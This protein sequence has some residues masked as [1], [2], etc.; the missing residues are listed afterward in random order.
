MLQMRCQLV[1]V[2]LV[3]SLALSSSRLIGQARTEGQLSGKVA[4]PSG[5]AVAGVNLTLNQAATGINVT[6]TSTGS[7]EYVFATVLPGTY[8]LT[9]AAKGFS[10]AVYDDVHVYTGRTTNLDLTLRVGSESQTVNVSGVSEVL[11]TTT[12][13]LTTT[14]AA[15]SIQNLPLNGRDVLPFAQLVPGA[16]VGGDLRFTTYN[17][18]PN[19]AISISLDGTNNNFQRFRTSTTGFF[20]AAALRVGAIDEVSISTSDLTADAAAEGAVTLR[21]TT[22]RGTNQFHGSAFWQAYNSAFNANS[23]QN[24]AYLG[25]GLTSLGRKQPFHTNDFGANIG[26]PII[27]NKLFFFFNFEWENQPSTVL[28]TQGV[29]TPAAQAGTFTYTRADNGQQQTVNLYNVAAASG[30]PAT[31]NANVQSALAAVNTLATKGTLSPNT[32][33]SYLQSLQNTLNFTAPQN[34]KQRWPTGRL[35]YVITPNIS[36]RASYDLYWRQYPRTPIYPDGPVEEGGFQSSYSTFSTGVNWTISSNL[37]NQTNFGILNTQERAQPGNSFNAFQGIDFVPVASPFAVNS[38]PAFTPTVPDNNSILPEPRNN[39]VWDFTDNMTWSHGKHTLTFGGHYRFSNQHDVNTQP[40]I[41]QNLG[42]SANDP[43]AA[44]FNTSAVTGCTQDTQGCFPGGLSTDNNNEALTDAEALYS[45]L[46]GRVASI[47]GL[48]P[49]DTTSKTYRE[50][51][52]TSIKEK[53]AVGGFYFQDGW[54]VTPNLSMNFG[55][56]WQFSSS[57]TNTDNYFTSPTLAD[58]Y[59]PSGGLFQPGVLSGNPN[60][61]LQLRA[62]SYPGD[63]RQPAPNFGFAWNPEAHDGW[64]KTFAGGHS[65]VI[66]GGVAVNHYDEGWIPWENVATGTLSNQTVS[67]N[68]GQFTPGSISFDATGGSIPPL[69][70]IPGSFSLPMPESAL[71]FTRDGAFST[72]DPKIRTPYIENW[73]FGF[74]KR[75]GGNWA[76]DV[77]YVGN[78]AVHMWEAFD[79]N[80]VNIFQNAPGLNSFLQDFQNA[81][82][83]LTESGGT[84][85]AG[86]HATPILSQA[87]AGQPIGSTFQNPN[88]LYLVQTGQA[89]ALAG[90][91]TRNPTFFCNLVGNTFSPCVTQ[92]YKTGAPGPLTYPINFFQVNPYSGGQALT[93]L[94]DPGSESYNGLQVQVKHPVGHG[95][96][97]MANYTYSHSFTNRYLGDYYQADG[98]LVDFTTLRNP[99]LNRVPSPYDLRNVFKTYFNY[100]LPFGKGT[101]FYSQH[102][103]VNQVIGGWTLGSVVAAQT[104]RNFKLAGGVNTYNYF[105]GPTPAN[106]NGTPAGI[107][108]YVPDENDSGV[109]LNGITPSQLQK[110]VG[111]Y[112]TGNPSAPVSVL[113]ASLFG[114]GGAIQ[115]SSTPGQLGSVIFLKGPKLFNTDLSVI[116]NIP[117]RENIK[118][119]LYAEML[120]VFNHPNFNFTDSYS[121]GTNNPAQYLLVNSSPYAP[122]T[123]GQNGN[124][125]IQF[126]IQVAF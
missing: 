33:D 97:F 91:I 47:S 8:K 69:N 34:T 64:M 44:M 32:T 53:Q 117:I 15:D 96:N 40:P 19:G 55:F 65:L 24:D 28:F 108:N 27:R 87:Y 80:E 20:E 102:A 13:T 49:L 85:F 6:A 58:L 120:N 26:G 63:F 1:A 12:N 30:Y 111:V 106:A 95:L 112:M 79:L 3:A 60:P 119:N 43:A 29:L 61:Q 7:G 73:T 25:A 35:D 86:S 51:G 16:Q 99:K 37:I 14:V 115:P 100:A 114:T 66:R 5:A 116:K 104:G 82:L 70:S 46:T 113:P 92:G 93:V 77:N 4:D 54:R 124:R 57:L 126:R 18:M 23:F 103:V 56:R 31:P 38:L 109:T 107:L 78:H 17:S 67:L 121:G 10:E 123:V 21:F 68:P 41:A 118:M 98:A 39:P 94:S 50:G 74:E 105:D 62:S 84:T 76:V 48:V 59:G 2:L 22:K 45:T 101:T 125:Q 42:I 11:E 90:A 52:V 9:V 36:W 89:G 110:K 88:N 72:V 122:G 71:T 81:Q 75:I 83:N